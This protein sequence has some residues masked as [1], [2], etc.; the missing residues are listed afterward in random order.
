MYVTTAL[1]E[2]GMS[3]SDLDK[4]EVT[5]PDGQITAAEMKIRNR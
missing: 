2:W 3:L 4:V 1:S 5:V